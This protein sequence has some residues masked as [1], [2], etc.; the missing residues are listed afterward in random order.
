MELQLVGIVM[1]LTIAQMVPYV[2]A[3]SPGHFHPLILAL[4]VLVMATTMPYV[5]SMPW[6]SAIFHV[7][8]VLIT[9]L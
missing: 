9:T 7:V 6:Q 3:P 4:E 1:A 5:A 2:Q 8:L